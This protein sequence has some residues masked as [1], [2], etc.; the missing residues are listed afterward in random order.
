MLTNVL[1]FYKI[2]FKRIGNNGV[3]SGKYENTI[4]NN[5]IQILFTI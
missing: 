1:G 5:L 3:L 4:P 2:Y